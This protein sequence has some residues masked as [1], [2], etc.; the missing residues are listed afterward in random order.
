MKKTYLSPGSSVVDVQL[1]SLMKTSLDHTVEG[2]Q[3]ITPD[4]NAEAPNE[5]TSRRQRDLWEDEEE[6]DEQY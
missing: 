3:T 4:V 2:P 1:A 5:F 6:E